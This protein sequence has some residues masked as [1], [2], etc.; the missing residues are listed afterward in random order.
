MYSTDI[1]HVNMSASAFPVDSAFAVEMS[2]GGLE[3]LR[4]EIRDAGA[5]DS[6]HV[7]GIVILV[8]AYLAFT[9][10]LCACC[11]CQ[12]EDMLKDDWR[13]EIHVR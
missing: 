11:Y 5:P 10:I 3:M 1:P 12:S 8:L 2:A 6:G 9:C 13:S 4:R 7:A